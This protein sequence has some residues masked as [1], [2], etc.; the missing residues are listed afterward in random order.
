MTGGAEFLF[1]FTFVSK[2]SLSQF[3]NRPQTQHPPDDNLTFNLQDGEEARY[4]S[5]D[6]FVLMYC[7]NLLRL[8][9]HILALIK[10]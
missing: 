7:V 4:L 6:G 10:P 1:A 2:D 5:V 8:I 9:A 3:S